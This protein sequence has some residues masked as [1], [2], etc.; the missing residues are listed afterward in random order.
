MEDDGCGPCS[1]WRK[2]WMEDPEGTELPMGG[3]DGAPLTTY[4]S[5][6]LLIE[7]GPPD[8]LVKAEHAEDIGAATVP[9]HD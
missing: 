3:I 6:A 1:R 7:L 4:C 5:E 8:A 9:W 2:W